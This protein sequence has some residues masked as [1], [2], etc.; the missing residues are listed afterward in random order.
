MLILKQSVGP[1]LNKGDYCHLYTTRH[2]PGKGIVL[3]ILGQHG[4]DMPIRVGILI[5]S[6]LFLFAGLVYTLYKIIQ[7]RPVVETTNDGF[8]ADGVLNRK[9]VPWST[10]KRFHLVK[11]KHYTAVEVV[12]VSGYVPLKE[13]SVVRKLLGIPRDSHQINPATSKLS[14]DQLLDELTKRLN[15]FNNV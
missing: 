1:W 10:V 5:I 12:M 7:N 3:M 8:L 9:L 11:L 14:A 15:Y 6:L 4:L 13:R 2:A